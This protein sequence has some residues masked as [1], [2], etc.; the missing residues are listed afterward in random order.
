MVMH[1]EVML[2]L[3]YKCAS[4][5]E[6]TN[7]APT[8]YCALTYSAGAQVGSFYGQVADTL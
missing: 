6:L 8:Y 3:Y 7:P 1:T 5:V 2:K 4:T